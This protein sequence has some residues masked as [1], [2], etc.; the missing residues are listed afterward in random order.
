MNEDDVGLFDMDGSLADYE[1]ALMRDMEM[2]RSPSEPPFDDPHDESQ[3]HLV[4]RTRLIKSQPG[5]WL[6][7]AP[8]KMGWDV[9][10]AALDL[11]FNNHILTKGPK[12]YPQAWKEKVEWCH[13]EIGPVADVHVV[14]DKKLVYGK[15]LYDDFPEYML[16]WL[17]FRPR[18]LGI[19]PVNRHNADFSHP[20]V[21][22]YT[23]DN[24]PFVIKALGSVKNRQSR[25]PFDLREIE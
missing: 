1:G 13:R 6:G 24:L 15:F 9:Y 22:K 2:L 12:R 14:S 7:L 5:W 23:G 20:Q 8:I 19:M 4:A 25:E 16:R 17:S 10:H 21:I 3:P 11:G 18:G